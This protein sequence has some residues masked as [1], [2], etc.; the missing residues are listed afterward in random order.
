[1]KKYTV[2]HYV[3]VSVCTGIFAINVCHA[4][5]GAVAALARENPEIMA[6]VERGLE[7]WAEMDVIAHDLTNIGLGLARN[8][9]AGHHNKSLWTNLSDKVAAAVGKLQAL[10]SSAQSGPLIMKLRYEALAKRAQRL[11]AAIS[12]KV[13]TASQGAATENKPAVEGTAVA[14][15]QQ[16]RILRRFPA[17]GSVFGTGA[18]RSLGGLPLPTTKEPGST[19]SSVGGTPRGAL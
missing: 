13:A 16:R 4:S 14:G 3:A 5:Q 1:M 7:V 11:G 8:K 18:G 12:A 9:A 2:G 15:Q 10:A 6:T 17:P 19:R